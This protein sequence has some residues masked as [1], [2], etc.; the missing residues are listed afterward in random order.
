VVPRRNSF[1]PDVDEGIFVFV[2]A[3]I[4]RAKPEAI[5]IEGGDSCVA[6]NALRNDIAWK[7]G[8]NEKL[9]AD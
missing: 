5:P 7:G 1:V 2:E 8:T 6:Q 3:V 9:N 4:A